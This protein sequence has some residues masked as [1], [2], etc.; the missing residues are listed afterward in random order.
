MNELD[1]TWISGFFDKVVGRVGWLAG[2]LAW[3]LACV[4][5][6]LGWVGAG[7]VRGG[8]VKC[9]FTI[10]IYAFLLPLS[11]LPSKNH[12]HIPPLTTTTS[13]SSSPSHI[14]PSSFSGLLHRD[15]RRMGQDR[16][17]GAG[18]LGYVL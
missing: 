17:R 4:V 9:L 3:V 6:G 1:G 8:V 5:G 15:A 2:W 7:D 11:A 16:R 12:T 18:A 14:T 13:S 10:I